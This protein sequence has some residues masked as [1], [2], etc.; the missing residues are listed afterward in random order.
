MSS[1]AGHAE[2]LMGSAVLAAQNH[3]SEMER[4]LCDLASV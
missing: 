1:Q 2:M 3:W 4:S